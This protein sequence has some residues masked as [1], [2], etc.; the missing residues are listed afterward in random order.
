MEGTGF[1]SKLIPC[2]LS[3]EFWLHFRYL[4][5]SMSWWG[6]NPNAVLKVVCM[7]S[8]SGTVAN[9]TINRLFKQSY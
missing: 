8:I 4:A 1:A 6:C 2:W 9:T 3:S 5:I 7:I